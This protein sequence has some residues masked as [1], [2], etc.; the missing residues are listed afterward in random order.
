M[1]LAIEICRFLNNEG[2]EA[3][4][5]KKSLLHWLSSKPSD[6]KIFQQKYNLQNNSMQ[7]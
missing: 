4:F 7:F 6:I 5:M 3:S 1:S 2:N